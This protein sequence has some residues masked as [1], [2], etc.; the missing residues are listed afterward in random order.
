MSN[1][2]TIE[3][4]KG[5][6]FAEVIDVI[7]V[8]EVKKAFQQSV[9]EGSL[10]KWFK[11]SKSKDGKPGWVNVV[12]G[13]TCA[14]DEKGEG[15]PK[16]VSSSKRA[17][18]TKAERLSA[19][20]R[21]KKADPGQ[22]AKSGA[23]K[24][25]YVATDKK[26]KMKEGYVGTRSGMGGSSVLDHEKDV[27]SGKLVRA[28]IEKK[29]GPRQL[30]KNYKP[31]K[32]RLKE[33]MKRD[34]YGD[35]IGGP[36]ISK[37]Q[38]KKNLTSNTP[39]EQHTTTTSEGY[40]DLPLEVE[41]PNT[42][43]KF[44]LGLMFRESLEV[45]KG[46]LFIFEE[47]GKHSFH[48]KNTRIPLDIAFVKE[49]GTIE[50]IKELKP[51]SSIP[52]YSDGEVLF[53]IEANRG[54][55]TEN[56]VEVGDE[57][58]LGEAKDKKGK[59]SG[60]KDACYH[61]VKSRYS[62]WPSAYASGALVK[63]RKVGA[64]NWG[65]KSESVE[66]DEKCWKG[67]EKKGMK[68]MFGKRYPNCVKKEE[69]SDWRDELGYEGKDDSKKLQEDDMKGMSV[70]S[71]HKRPTKSG[72]G[73]T[74]KGVEAYRRR[75]PGSKLQTAVTTKPSKLK[76]GS[77]AANRRKSYCARSAGQMKKFPKAAKDPNSRLRQ[78]RRRWN[79]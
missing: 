31:L 72:A 62:V 8:S 74:Q 5:E 29:E 49:D 76:K 28:K 14:S 54:W 27:K 23:A 21:K 45:D 77:K 35:P 41:I 39:D 12:T 44:R 16:C 2:V 55:F 40:I 56:N 32:D 79:C 57:I 36:K 65:N 73:M 71:G 18:M 42:D 37:K 17:S 46:M 11:G 70:K 20:R 58:V 15:T 43:G 66:L 1:S 48:M 78:A 47:V 67:Y 63:C 7:G 59:G 3:D 10:H 6:T 60:T 75:N 4:S 38:L 61:K 51:Y 50:S 53:A 30:P 33:D 19:S 52:V 24:P 64:A 68:T 69:F 22:Q 9:K 25:T 26:K 34:E 13:G